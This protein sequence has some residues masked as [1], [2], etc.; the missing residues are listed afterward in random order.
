MSYVQVAELESL[1][2]GLRA[3]VEALF[4]QAPSSD[5]EKL[6]ERAQRERL[7][8]DEQVGP[9]CNIWL[10]NRNQNSE[11][12]KKFKTSADL[13]KLYERA[14]R[15]RLFPDK[16]VICVQDKDSN[17]EIENTLAVWKHWPWLH[18]RSQRER[19]VLDEDCATGLSS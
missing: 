11:T 3:D 7:V 1:F 12:R 15:E 19:L 2:G 9:L 4:M 10:A 8:L 17:H 14:Q 6:Y 18:E 13:E 5:L 16:Q